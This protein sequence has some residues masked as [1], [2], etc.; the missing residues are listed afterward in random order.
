MLSGGLQRVNLIVVALVLL[1]N[2]QECVPGCH[3]F[4]TGIQRQAQVKVPTTRKPFIRSLVGGN[5]CVQDSSTCLW[6][7]GPNNEKDEELKAVEEESRLKILKSRRDTIRGTLKG[8]ESLSNFRIANGTYTVYI[9]I[10]SCRPNFYC[11]HFHLYASNCYSYNI[12]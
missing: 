6:M 10:F 7:A 12:H 9:Y 1:G 4:T 3:A 5:I 2:K 11:I 8:S